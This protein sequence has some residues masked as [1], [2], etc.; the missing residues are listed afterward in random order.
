MKLT[1]FNNLRKN[2]GSHSWKTALD[3]EIS[4]LIKNNVWSL[5]PLPIDKKPVGSKFIFKKKVGRDGNISEYKC[6]L[7]AQGYAQKFGIDFDETFCPVVRFETVISLLVFSNY[8]D[9]KLHH[10]DVCSALY[11]RI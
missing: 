5:K 1:L 7:V 4:S 11:K 10:M 6:R 9:I 8:N 2:S 3:K